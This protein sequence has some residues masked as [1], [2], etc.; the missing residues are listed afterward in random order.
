VDPDAP[1]TP[2][3]ARP[4]E[5]RPLDARQR[6][7]VVGL[8][9]GGHD[10]V[11]EQTRHEIHRIHH[12]YLRTSVHPSADLVADAFTFDHLYERADTFDDVYLEITDTLVAA[13]QEHGEVLYAVPGSP[14]VLERSVRHL[15]ERDDVEVTVLPAMSF[16]DVVWARLGIDPIEAGVRLVDGHEFATAAA[17]ERGPMLVAHAHADW[18]LSEIKLAVEGASGDEPV[19]ILQALGTPQERIVETTWSELDRTIT[20]DHLTSLWIPHLATPVGAE[21]VRFHQLTRLLR[22]QCPWDIEQTHDSLIPHLLEEAYEVVDAIQALDADDPSTDEELIEELG[23]LLYQIE[24][25]ATIAEQEGRFTIADVASGIHDKLVRRHP[26]VFGDL[27]GDD[28]D[29]D[30]VLSNWDDIK[31]AEKSRTSVFDG[32]PRSMPALSYA[33]KVGAKASKVG[34]DWPDVTGAFPKIAEETAELF[35]TLDAT[36]RMTGT[37]ETAGELGDLLFAIVNVARHLR[38]DPELALR[39][40][41]DKFRTRFEGVERLAEQRSI[42]LRSADLAT[43]DAL[44][45]DVKAETTDG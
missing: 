36:N 31:R 14:L 29:T 40:A 35:D 22:E 28:L 4:L 39:A 11:T 9:P 37:E 21:Y 5:A 23:D 18:V 41:T 13:A 44:W 19:T 7:V 3:E 33:A 27:V 30:Q 1:T 45:D 6:I 16:L 26:H 43:L 34:F 42:D 12:R 2:V 25:H 38:I 20:A 8:G 24:F 17:G 10:H 32:I 15:L